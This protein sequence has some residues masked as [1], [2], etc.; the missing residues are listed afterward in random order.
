VLDYKVEVSHG[1]SLGS[2]LGDLL[3][4]ELGSKLGESLGAEL[5]TKLAL[6]FEAGLWPKARIIAWYSART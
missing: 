6:V 2:T 4:T 5:G 1:S 3:G